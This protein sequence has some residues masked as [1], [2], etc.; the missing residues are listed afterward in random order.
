MKILNIF[1]F[2]P[3]EVVVILQNYGTY[4]ACSLNRNLKNTKYQCKIVYDVFGQFRQFSKI[5]LEILE[6]IRNHPTFI[7]ANA[8]LRFCERAIIFLNSLRFG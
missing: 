5:S 7:A 6:I 2:F 1:L 3:Y 4:Y 8:T